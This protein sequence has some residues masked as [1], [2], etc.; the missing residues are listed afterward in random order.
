MCI[1]CVE[2]EKNKLTITEA[3]RAL[4]E[5]RKDLSEEHVQEIMIKLDADWWIQ[6]LENMP[7]TD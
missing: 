7:Q 1:I 3:Y 5:M 4:H 2:Y 6:W